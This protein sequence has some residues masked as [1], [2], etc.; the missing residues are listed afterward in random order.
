MKKDKASGKNPNPSNAVFNEDS[1]YSKIFHNNPTPHTL[2]K[3]S[4]RSLVDVNEA[5]E[6]FTGYKKEEVLGHTVEDLKLICLSE[7]NSIRAF[8]AE[9]EILKSY[10]LEV[11]KKNGDTTYG[12]ATFQLVNLGGDEFVQ[13]SILDISSLKHTEN[14]LYVSKNFMESLLDSMYEA[15]FV[16]DKQLRC[17]RINKAYTD[18]TGYTEK[19][20]LGTKAPFPHWPQEEYNNI[21]QYV[22]RCLAGNLEK[23]ELILKKAKQ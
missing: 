13:S 2:A 19:D 10:E 21:Q 8:L 22:K 7:A 23:G 3:K 11:N 18:L 5:W 15:I 14:E 12:L 16:L 6:K 9:Q 17:V 1:I 4:D 20:V